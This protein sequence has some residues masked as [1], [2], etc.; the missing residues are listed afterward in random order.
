MHNFGQ[1]DKKTSSIL[2]TFY[3]IHLF[4]FISNY[5][6]MKYLTVIITALM[7][8]GCLTA[9]VTQ[10][11]SKNYPV[12]APE[13]VTIYLSEEDIPNEFEK[14][15]IIY[16]K[17]DHGW[18]N[19]SQQYEL[20]RTKAAELGANGVLIVG[21]TDPKTGAKV[22]QALIGTAANRKGEMIAIYVFD[23]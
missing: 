6:I 20:A 14:V 4:F 5:L 2:K 16:T 18:T 23:D 3:H 10:L 21:I 1:K 22:A 7:L 17:G 13:D 15:A 19:E 8:S 12:L 9:S 11:S